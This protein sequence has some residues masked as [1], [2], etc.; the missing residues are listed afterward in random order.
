MSAVDRGDGEAGVP[1]H[2][3]MEG[4]VSQ[5]GAVDVIGRVRFDGADHVSRVDVFESYGEVRLLLEMILHD[6]ERIGIKSVLE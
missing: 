6:K 4:A 3:T 2:G 5:Q 1:C